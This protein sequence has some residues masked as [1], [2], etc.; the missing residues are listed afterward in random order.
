ML[1]RSVSFNVAGGVGSLAIGFVAS[2][3]TARLLGPADRGVLA[4]ITYAVVVVAEVVGLALPY[5]VVFLASKPGARRGALLGNSLAWGALLAVVFVPGF[6]LLAEPLAE[7]FSKGSGEAAWVVGGLLV[8]LM[9]LDWSI[10]NQLFGKLRF[11]LLNVLFVLSRLVALASVVVLVG[12]LDLGVLGALLASMI[13]AGFMIAASLA[14]I[15]REARPELDLPLLRTML[16]YGARVSVGSIFQI[17]NYR[18]DLLVLQ[19]YVPLSSV[20]YYVVAQLVAELAL[21]A[22]SAFQ[23][24]LTTLSSHYEGDERQAQMTIS[25]L[26]HQGVLTALTIGV[27]AAAGSLVILFAYGPDFRAALVP[28]LILLPG[29][30]FLATAKVVTGD[31]RGRGRPGL[32]STLAGLTVFITLAL[33]FALIPPFGVNGAAV[34]SLIAYTFFGLLSLAVLS[35]TTGVPVRT[36]VLPTNVEFDAYRTL[37]RRALGW[38][39]RRQL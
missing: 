8:P 28:M 5:A 38:L 19:F 33:D 1:A 36:L 22:A 12:L 10:H 39:G 18:A 31:L 20:G 30:W 23:T 25:S 26:R 3:V 11:G 4:L 7:A 15:L 21:A 37:W 2:I 35:R 29:M 6:W 34:A 9:F 17:V 32:S 16:S 13:A 14:V 27:N 24:S